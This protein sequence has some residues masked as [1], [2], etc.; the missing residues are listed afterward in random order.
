M[1]VIT[2]Y[3]LGK[4]NEEIYMMQLEGFIQIGM[5]QNMVC[6]LLY[7]IYSLTQ[8]VRVWNLK[9]HTFLIKIISLDL[10]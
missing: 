9:I 6:Q 8:V 5:K 10:V 2:A 7:S 4:L 3:L 1:D